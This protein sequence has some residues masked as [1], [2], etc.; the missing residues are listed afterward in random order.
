MLIKIHTHIYK[1]RIK[2][3]ISCYFTSSISRIALSLFNDFFFFAENYS[4]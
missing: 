1:H 3:V 2:E 4:Q